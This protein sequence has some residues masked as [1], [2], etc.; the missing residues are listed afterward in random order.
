M[1]KEL[2]DQFEVLKA[3][4]SS[5]ESMVEGLTEEQ[6][7]AKPNEHFNNV[8]SIVDHIARVERKF[9]SALTGEMEQIDAMETFKASRWDVPAIRQAFADVIPFA[10]TIFSQLTAEDMDAFGL[11][12][13]TLEL[14]KRQVIAFTMTHSTHHRGQI[15]L[16]LKLI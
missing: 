6:W 1:I 13:R 5:I 11:K 15:P 8:A 10:K 9:L 12:L 4:H 2:A 14:N 3:V 16:V 7:L